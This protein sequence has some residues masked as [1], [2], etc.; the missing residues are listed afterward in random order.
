METKVVNIVIS[1]L[2]ILC[3]SSCAP[4]EVDDCGFMQNVYGQRIAWK[5]QEP[6][7]LHINNSVPTELKPAI[8]RAAATWENAI[9]RKMFNLVEN[10]TSNVGRDGKNGVYFLTD[11]EQ[12][13]RSEQGRA[14]IYWADDYIYE[15]DIR[16][17][18]RD[19]SFYNV[20]GYGYNF[21]ALM[22]HE[23][24]HLLGL[25]HAEGVMKSELTLNEDRTVLTAQ[26]IKSIQCEYTR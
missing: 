12:D 25:K 23:L 20:S 19:H 3:I 18:G 6:I 26:D 10:D 14:S 15:S 21:E 9:G 24:G 13:R 16:I 22:L 17:N 4:K 2:F 5:N 1:L 7:T 11:W 8:Y